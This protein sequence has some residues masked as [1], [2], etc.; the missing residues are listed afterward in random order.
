[1]TRRSKIWLLNDFQSLVASSSSYSEVLR[2]INIKAGSGNFN[3]LKARIQSEG[4]DTSHFGG[5]V[6]RKINIATSSLL[7][8]DSNFSRTSLKRRLLKEGLIENKCAICGLGAEWRRQT[9]VL[10]LD[11]IN[12]NP[13]DNQIENLR[14]LCPNCNSQQTTF[15][16]RKNKKEKERNFCQCGKEI[17]AKSQ[18]C[19]QCNN[20]RFRR[21]QRP[22][23]ETLKLK[24]QRDGIAAVAT[25]YKV[26][27]NAIRKWLK[28]KLGGS[29]LNRG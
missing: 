18:K 12:G 6:P 7:V 9:L 19:L 24:V 25:E 23:L 14:M 16:G 15:A 27:S 11:H 20:A 26:S 10:V 22:P 8:S 17:G 13:S 2:K 1:M 4:V 21:H 5:R 3:T 28:D 29:D